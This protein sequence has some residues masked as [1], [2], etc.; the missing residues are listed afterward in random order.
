MYL[1]LSP[2]LIVLLSPLFIPISA[3][4]QPPADESVCDGLSGPSWGLCNAYC[5]AMDCESENANASSAACQKVLSEY[6]THTEQVIP[7]AR[8][9]CPCWAPED[10]DT[11]LSECESDAL[12]VACWD[13]VLQG[14]GSIFSTAMEC[15]GERGPVEIIHYLRATIDARIAVRA[16]CASANV[17]PLRNRARE[18]TIDQASA[19]GEVLTDRFQD[20]DTVTISP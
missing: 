3:S 15:S 17:P 19:C 14:Q 6:T 18:I 10:V 5:E 8:V 12:S 7:C 13:V 9:E 20:C 16:S 4:A 2:L 1:Y 11:L